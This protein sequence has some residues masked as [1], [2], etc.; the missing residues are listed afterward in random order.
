MQA[1]GTALD[2][3]FRFEVGRA[4]SPRTARIDGSPRTARTD[5]SPRTAR[6]DSE[7]L[8]TGPRWVRAHP[9]K[10]GVCVGVHAS[11]HHGAL[12]APHRCGR[13]HPNWGRAGRRPWRS[14]VK[15][16]RVCPASCM[17]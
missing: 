15:R 16:W 17:P 11:A 6:T 9:P 1:L 7:R 14:F 4:G 8:Q 10:L 12:T 3:R 13:T 5:G 2:A